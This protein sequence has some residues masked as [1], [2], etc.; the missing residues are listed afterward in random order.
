VHYNLKLQLQENDGV[1]V[2]EFEVKDVTK[3]GCEKASPDQFDLLRVL[4]QGSFGK[5]RMTRYESSSQHSTHFF[6]QFGYN[7]E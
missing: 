3:E 2:N 1:V 6:C 7:M 4:G 5:V